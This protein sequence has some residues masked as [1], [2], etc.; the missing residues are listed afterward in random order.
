M[1]NKLNF[2]FI[3]IILSFLVIGAVSASNDN[4]TDFVQKNQDEN[5]IVSDDYKDTLTYNNVVNLDEYSD[6]DFTDLNDSKL[7][8]LKNYQLN[9]PSFDYEL[10]SSKSD[11]KILTSSNF[12]KSGD[13]YFV[14]LKDSNDIPVVNKKLTVNFNKKTQEYTTDND[15]SIAINVNLP[16]STTSM[17]VSF[18]GDDIYNKLSK[19]VHVNVLESKDIIIG[20]SKL[21][22]NG[23]LRIYLR[24][25]SD[26]ISNKN[27]KIKI[28]HKV[29]NEKTNEEGFVVIKPDLSAG[30]YNVEVFFDNYK[31]SKKIKC[32]KGNVIN[33]YK[34]AIPMEDGVPDIDYMSSKYVM[35]DEDGKYCLK[36]SQYKKAIKRDSYSLYLYG[37]LPK[38]TFFATKDC[39]HYYHIIKREKWN[40]IEQKLNIKRVKHNVK[41]YW[42]ETITASLKGKAL[43]Y[44]EVRDIQ[45]TPYTCGPT[46]ASMCSQALRNYHSEKYFQIKAH[47]VS[48]VN[49]PVL[50]KAVDS[51]HFKSYYFYGSTINKAVKTVAKG[52]AALIAFLPG[53]YVSIIDASSDGKKVLVSNS[54]R[55]YD[56]G[57]G[58][59]PTGWV[60]LKYFKTRFANIGLVVKLNY[61]LGSHTKEKMKNLY[62]TMGS[63]SH[64]N[65]INERIPNVPI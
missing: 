8:S 22:T 21:L 57:S 42:P 15:G 59:V 29:F 60:S 51:T 2:F 7:S 23:Y 18:D 33:F 50:K 55:S 17:D 4:S 47:V 3:L 53:H 52:G 35:A 39:P 20:N 13:Y 45:N 26:F 5:I 28:G 9:S 32:I 38:F 36:K 34:N 58:K 1:K 46:S 30:T 31:T 65:N 48:G 11:L 61:S 14:Y 16:E 24:G 12:V 43:T 25:S 63:G 40:V 64:R 56:M 10:T 44:S 37:K 19:T 41:S 27:I 49:I 62:L 6:K 54:Y